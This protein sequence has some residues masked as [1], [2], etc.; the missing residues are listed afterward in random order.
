MES[1]D[2]R[3]SAPDAERPTEKPPEGGKVSRIA[4]HTQ[5]LFTDLRE[6]ID[7]RVDLAILEMEERLDTFKN[8]VA[9]GL[10]IAVFAALA[11]F[12]SLTTVALGV[13]WLLGHPFWGFLAVSVAL[14][15]IIV[16]LRVA[17]PALMP[18][19]NLLESLRREQDVSGDESPAR[20]ASAVVDENAS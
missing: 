12:F 15:L 10:T 13:G 6:W 8:D 19:S 14:I 2:D 9:L 11:A 16:A 4:A 1:L 5:G 7:L 17:K 18:P 3:S 20:P